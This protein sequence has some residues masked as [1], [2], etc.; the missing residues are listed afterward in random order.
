MA[1]LTH[2]WIHAARS[3]SRR[4]AAAWL[5]LLCSGCAFTP[6]ETASAR[7]VVGDTDVAACRNWYGRLDDAVERAG[8][9]DAA[10]PA[11]P[12]HRF[13]RVDR[14]HASLR[15]HLPASP[16]A[17]AA[18]P[19][20]AALMA[21]LLALDLQARQH[22]ITNLPRTSRAALAGAPHGPAEPD[23]L[24]R[25]TRACGRT[26]VQAALAQPAQAHAVLQAL[27]VPPDYVTAYRA[28]GLYPLT[29]IPFF[30]G[31][32]QFEDTIRD[33]FQQDPV[34]DAGTT[35]MLL[36]PPGRPAPE[37][38]TRERLRAMLKPAPDDPLRIPEPSPA[39]LD[40]LFAQFAP[41]FALGIRSDDD[42]IGALHWPDRKAGQ[43]Q[44]GTPVPDTDQPV[45][46]R[47]IAWTRHGQDS[48]LQLVY[49]IWFG[50][51]TPTSWPIDLLAGRLDGLVW[52][53]TLS[54]NGVPLM[55]DSIHPCGC[56]HQFFPPP[57]VRPRPAPAPGAEWAF[58]PAPAPPTAPGQSLVLR[59]APV[60]H[61]LTRLDARAQPTGTPYG[62][63]DY[64]TLRSLPTPE[65]THRSVFDAHGFI[66]GTD[67]AEAWLFWPMGIARAGTMRQWGRH[68]TAFVGRRHFDDARLIEQRFV[69]EAPPRDD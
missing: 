27:S 31:V 1:S 64:D 68:A 6:P 11:V 12:G 39:H 49:T 33:A 30:H 46:Y 28:L 67:R 69:L 37:R 43:Q 32:R 17:P 23:D 36:V 8:V 29:R 59:V 34:P 15:D 47:Q 51:R 25:H 3:Y 62:W 7:L 9:R 54:P 60:T 38:V 4:A 41:A 21:R 56:Y 20:R 45:V 18:A 66:A 57:W 44:G 13:L 42:R 2:Q 61:Y 35:R 24:L 53:V 48:L 16:D 14:Y 22:E 10:A 50:A 58:S 65:G 63:R 55:Y 26:L 19:A 52:R 5:I 40:I